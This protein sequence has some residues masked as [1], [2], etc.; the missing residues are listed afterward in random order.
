M[1]H[2]I[3]GSGAQPTPSAAMSRPTLLLPPI[4][5]PPP[6]RPVMVTT[7]RQA[8]TPEYGNRISKLLHNE[9]FLL[10]ATGVI[11]FLLI[12][13]AAARAGAQAD[14]AQRSRGLLARLAGQVRHEDL[15]DRQRDAHREAEVDRGSRGW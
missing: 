15:R 9:R 11:G 7:S 5:A 12:W 2:H 1:T 4:A 3:P 13:E 8:P 14:V 10:G 6:A